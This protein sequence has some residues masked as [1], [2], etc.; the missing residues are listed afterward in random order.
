MQLRLGFKIGKPKVLNP[1]SANITKWSNTLKQFVGKYI[2]TLSSFSLYQLYLK[3]AM[4]EE[5]IQ[6]R[7]LSF[8]Y[9]RSTNYERVHVY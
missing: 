7:H 3:I 8:H 9:N 1:L 6:V 5:K 2:V 4:P